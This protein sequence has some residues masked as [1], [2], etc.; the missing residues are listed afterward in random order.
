MK[1]AFWRRTPVDPGKP[2]AFREPGSTVTVVAGQGGGGR[3]MAPSAVSVAATNQFL[4]DEE[5]RR[6]AVPGCGRPPTH[7]LHAI[8]D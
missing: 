5:T 1:L 3:G 4:R 7:D 8:E 6:C 2:H